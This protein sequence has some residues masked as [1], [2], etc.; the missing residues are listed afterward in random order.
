MCSH[1]SASAG[2]NPQLG[3]D[4][5]G[6]GR[7]GGTGRRPHHVEPSGGVLP[8]QRGGKAQ[9]GRVKPSHAYSPAGRSTVNKCAQFGRVNTPRVYGLVARSTVDSRLL[10]GRVVGSY[11]SPFTSSHWQIVVG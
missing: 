7:A 10:V 2:A 5:E 4:L 11:I 3:S 8:R 1:F 6:G 9:F